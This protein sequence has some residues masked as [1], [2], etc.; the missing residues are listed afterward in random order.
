MIK[1]TIYLILASIIALASFS[2]IISFLLPYFT[3]A[4]FEP[5]PAREVIKAAKL[6]KISTNAKIVDLGSGNGNVV[7]ELAK[8]Y[9]KAKI[10]GYEINPFLVAY[11]KLKL[12]KLEIKNVRIEWKNFWRQN[13]SKFN[14]VFVFGIGYIM[15]KLEDKI[16]REIKRGTV[17]SYWW[18]FPT[19]KL[20]RQKNKIYIYQVKK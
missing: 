10:V 14:V 8:L 15:A 17:V 12:K 20:I 3:G 4:P 6:A 18:R 13:L 11:S 5:M 19:L 2:L 7:V 1:M 9:P 16:K